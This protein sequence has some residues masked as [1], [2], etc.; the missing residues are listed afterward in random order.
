M[1]YSIVLTK[2][3][4][5]E[6]KVLQKKYPSL[7][8]NLALLFCSLEINPVQGIALGKG[9]YKIRLAITS[10]G[11]GKSS[12]ARI[13]SFVQ[14][15][16]ESVLLLTIYDKSVRSSISDKEIKDILHNYIY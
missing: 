11:K 16:D 10:K 6:A 5:R 1:S 9:L 14:I 7:K 4:K 13:I 15:M 2:D 3:F 8:D 12:G